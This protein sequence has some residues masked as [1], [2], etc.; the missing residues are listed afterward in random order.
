MPPCYLPL[1]RLSVNKTSL[2]VS[3][4]GEREK[5]R[6]R[7]EPAGNKKRGGKRKNIE[8]VAKGR[9]KGSGGGKTRRATVGDGS[10]GGTEEEEEE[11]ERETL[12]WL[13][14]K[15]R[16][17]PEHQAD[18]KTGWGS[19]GG[20]VASQTLLP[21]PPFPLLPLFLLLPLLPLLLHLPAENLCRLS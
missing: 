5:E 21:P 8:L 2:R 1:C 12:H 10:E 9:E 18:E 11:L 19:S 15:Q 3:D 7:T 20:D 14:D 4:V 6:E 13:A 16:V 17:P